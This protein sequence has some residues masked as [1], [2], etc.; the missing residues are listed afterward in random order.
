VW[1]VSGERLPDAV[2]KDLAGAADRIVATT[3]SSSRPP[4]VGEVA[5]NV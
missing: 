1:D 4:R 5:L 2:A 3:R